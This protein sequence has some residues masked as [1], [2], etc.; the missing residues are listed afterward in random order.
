MIIKKTKKVVLIFLNN[1][2]H[3]ENDT[4][5]FIEHISPRYTRFYLP[6]VNDMFTLDYYLCDIYKRY[7]NHSFMLFLS[8]YG[9]IN[10]EADFYLGNTL[11]SFNEL[12]DII[13]NFSNTTVI[14]SNIVLLASRPLKR[15]RKYP[16]VI[17]HFKVLANAN[18]DNTK[19]GNILFSS[20][21]KNS[22]FNKEI[23]YFDWVMMLSKYLD[24][25]NVITA[26]MSQGAKRL[27]MPRLI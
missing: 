9:N 13:N 18:D 25:N 7:P 5:K 1:I 27:L 14:L 20:I 22:M 3:Y 16:P 11:H 12:Y 4:K 19:R 17:E 15:K 6:Y 26:K 23:E 2:K 21:M 10:R 8:V 24:D